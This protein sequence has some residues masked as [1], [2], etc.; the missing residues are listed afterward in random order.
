MPSHLGT[1]PILLVLA[2]V[3]AVAGCGGGAEESASEQWAG[4]VCSELSTW[5]TEVEEAVTSLS[6]DALSLDQEAVRAATDD[7]REA[8][9]E[10]V[11]GLADLDRPETEA[12]EQASSELDE[13]GAQL[14]QQ[15]EEVEQAAE[16]GSLSLV[17][18]TG[19]LAAAASSVRST[20][21][22]LQTLDSGEEL[23]DGFESAGSCDSFREQVDT[24]G[25]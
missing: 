2:A 17:A 7:V 21:E 19:A 5:V 23:R 12:G 9:D 10:L 15:L 24:V 16:T 20:F 22:S 13:L 14:T 4:D 18:V 8:T 3:L 6:E 25:D 11:D 1:L